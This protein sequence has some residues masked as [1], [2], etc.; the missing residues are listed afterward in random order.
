MREKIRI[1]SIKSARVMTVTEAARAL[2]V[3]T[4]TVR[5]WIRKGLPVLANERPTVLRGTDLKTWLAERKRRR[6]VDLA[7]HEFMCLRCKAA[8]VPLGGLV[9]SRAQ[10]GRTLRLEALC[11]VCESRM[12]RFATE[13]ALTEI[14]RLFDV[15]LIERRMP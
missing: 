12:Y 6:H 5:D 10:N 13:G 11:A 15:N 4:G 14:R 3:S 2:R 9:D 1:R 7:P 8:R